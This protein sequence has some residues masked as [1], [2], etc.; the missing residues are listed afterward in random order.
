MIQ[1]GMQ[2]FSKIKS[3]YV[4]ALISAI[5]FA[6]VLFGYVMVGGTDLLYSHYPLLM[7]GHKN[8]LEFGNLGLWNPDIFAGHDMSSEMH[9][10]YL[11]PFLWWIFLL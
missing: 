7:W 3:I 1:A 4:F 6:K 8:F 9:A 2:T 11:N 10:H 5:L